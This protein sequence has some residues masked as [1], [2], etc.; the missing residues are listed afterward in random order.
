MA[1][2][3]W[4]AWRRL[5]GLWGDRGIT[6]LAAKRKGFTIEKRLQ[7]LEQVTGSHEERLMAFG[8]MTWLSRL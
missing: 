5:E 2:A 4:G 7:L 3:T 8:S 1:G 6:E